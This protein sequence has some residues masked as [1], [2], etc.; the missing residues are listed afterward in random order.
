MHRRRQQQQIRDHFIIEQVQRFGRAVEGERR[1]V[2]CELLRAP[3]DIRR[4]TFHIDECAG[5]P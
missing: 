1:D 4:M 5:K 3:I 2:M